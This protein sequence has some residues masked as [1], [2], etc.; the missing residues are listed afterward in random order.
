[1]ASA[2]LY[3]RKTKAAHKHSA[4]SQLM[5]D[6]RRQKWEEILVK[7]IRASIPLAMAL[8]FGST[9]AHAQKFD[10][11]IGVGTAMDSSS[12]QTYDTF[13]TGNPF[14][15]P[16][17]AGS[18]GKVGADFMF[19]PHFG[20]GAETDFRFSQAAY[21]GL[22]YRPTFYDFNGIWMP[23]AHAK[24]V[25][26]EFQAGLGAVNLKFYYPQSYC[27]AFAGCSTSNTFVE[28]SNHFQIHMMAGV[29]FYATSHLFIRPQ[30]D[31]RYV[32]NFFQFGNNWVPEYGGSI[33]WTFGER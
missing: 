25:V 24:R 33:G 2:R 27:D 26:P 10:A 14:T 3:L 28:S 21:L 1:M 15:T 4:V 9:L 19:T 17:L 30:V 8:F 22:N 5:S 23:I 6:A 16:R 32:D 20:V 11:Y 31:V 7:T 18:V 12:G 29:R 13:S